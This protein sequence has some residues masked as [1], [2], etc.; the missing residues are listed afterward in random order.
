MFFNEQEAT[1]GDERNN[2]RVSKVISNATVQRK[3]DDE[4]RC[5]VYIQPYRRNI[6]ATQE[7]GRTKRFSFMH[8]LGCFSQHIRTRRSQVRSVHQPM[9]RPLSTLHTLTLLVS[10]P[11]VPPASRSHNAPVCTC[12]SPRFMAR[13]TFFRVFLWPFRGSFFTLERVRGI[14]SPRHDLLHYPKR[15]SCTHAFLEHAVLSFEM[16]ETFSAQHTNR[17]PRTRKDPRDE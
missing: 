12:I 10:L 9:L 16:D 8:V 6:P 3:N 1:F 11:P 7:K 17:V 13:K 5:I 15:S 14:L 2:A 4:M